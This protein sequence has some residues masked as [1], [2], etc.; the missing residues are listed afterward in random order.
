MAEV[1]EKK[2][3]RLGSILNSYSSIETLTTRSKQVYE[4]D[5]FPLEN[6]PTGGEARFNYV[7][8]QILTKQTLPSEESRKKVTIGDTKLISASERHQN[9]VK[10]IKNLIQL[11]DKTRANKIAAEKNVQ[12]YT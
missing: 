12:I 5:K 1:V 10:G 8:Q 3:S 6:F 9:A 4:G 7:A 2:A 11:I